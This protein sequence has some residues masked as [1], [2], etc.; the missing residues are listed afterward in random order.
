MHTWARIALH[1]CVAWTPVECAIYHVSADNRASLL[2]PVD[3]EPDAA[4]T[5]PVED[6]LRSGAKPVSSRRYIEEYYVAARFNYAIACCL[7]GERSWALAH[8]AK[9]RG[10]LGFTKKRSFLQCIVWI[11]SW[12]VKFYMLMKRILLGLGNERFIHSAIF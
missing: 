1:Y 9:T 2:V 5:L 12:L 4:F 3:L 6:F 11:P 7:E 8:I 10:I